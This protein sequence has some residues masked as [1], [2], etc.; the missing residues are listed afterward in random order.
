[1]QKAQTT[2]DVEDVTM[3]DVLNLASWDRERN[4]DELR[5]FVERRLRVVG[6]DMDT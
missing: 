4:E 6:D 3:S 2:N 1:M 5:S